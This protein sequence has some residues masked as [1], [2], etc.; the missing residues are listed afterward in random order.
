MPNTSLPIAA[1]LMTLHYLTNL[2][3]HAL[4]FNGLSV[5]SHT[6]H[7]LP[8]FLVPVQEK[9]FRELA[10]RLGEVENACLVYTTEAGL[11]YAA[12][13][14]EHSAFQEGGGDKDGVPALFAF[15]PFLSKIPDMAS[16]DPLSQR[17][18]VAMKEFLSGLPLVKSSQLQSFLNVLHRIRTIRQVPVFYESEKSGDEKQGQKLRTEMDSEPEYALIDLRYEL[19]SRIV[20][21]VKNGD[22]QAVQDILKQSGNLYDFSE[23]FPN[24]P[25]R[26]AK[27]SLII[28]NTTLRLAAESAGVPPFYLHHLSEKFAIKIERINSVEA[29]R[30]MLGTM[31][32]EYCDLV[33]S[34]AISG[35]SLLVQ[36]AL[37]HLAVHYRNPLGL[38][39]LAEQLDV[40]PAHLS[41]Q[42]KKETGMTMTHYLNQTR[43][44]KAKVL[45]LKDRSSI[46]WI[47]GAVGF[48]DAAY[49]T[50]VFK[51]LAGTTPREYRNAGEKESS[52][53]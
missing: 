21:G 26:A 50:R 9:A 6:P 35:Y 5:M 7:I 49:F 25:V 52:Q 14:Y 41:R 15:G 48:A 10:D 17:D 40:H 16:K 37:G 22:K 47:A 33:K 38:E 39:E 18:R 30:K 2:N 23:R 44:E 36:T 32:D 3:V 4:H 42:F 13:A 11:T 53:Q 19:N 27:N 43:V 29:F 45:L 51:K 20:E 1:E 8:P 46:D 24:Q 34:Q 31:G 28:L 12:G